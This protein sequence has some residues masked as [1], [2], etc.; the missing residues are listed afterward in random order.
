MHFKQSKFQCDRCEY[1]TSRQGRLMIHLKAAHQCEIDPKFETAKPKRRC[2]YCG[3][4]IKNW[5]RHVM[6]MHMNIKNFFCDLCSYSSFFKFDME[7]HVV[8][9]HVKRHQKEAQ[10]YFCEICGMKFDKRFHLNAHSRSKHSAKERIHKCPTCEKCKK[11]ETSYRQ[12][13]ILK[14]LFSAFFSSENLKKHTE[15]HGPKEM[16]CEFCG[17]LFSCMNNLRTHLYYHSDPKFICDFP[18][19]DKKF[20]MRKRL[21]A[22]LKVIRVM[23]PN[24]LNL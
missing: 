8:K 16:P 12:T 4:I 6:K 7:Q 24:D 22:H 14:Y 19:C 9:V 5:R 18:N 17:K 2:N 20:Y 3:V 11:L 13:E 23:S 21:R 10:K 15:S 1:K